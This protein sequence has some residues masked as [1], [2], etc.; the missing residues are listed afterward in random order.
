MPE[1][2]SP[3]DE[4]EEACLRSWGARDPTVDFWQAPL[5]HKRAGGSTLGCQI[6]RGSDRGRPSRL[7]F[8]TT[9]PALNARFIVVSSCAYRACTI[10]Q[11]RAHSL[12][13]LPV[14]RKE[15]KGR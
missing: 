12:G 10:T 3:V 13:V 5:Y 15:G 2:F 8:K 7:L 1:A 11:G 14:G 4:H 9:P 6:G